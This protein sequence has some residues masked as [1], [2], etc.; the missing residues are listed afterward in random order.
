MGRTGQR[1]ILRFYLLHRECVRRN[2]RYRRAYRTVQAITDPERHAAE[3]V[4]LSQSWGLSPSEDPP[5]PDNWPQADPENL[6]RDVGATKDTIDSALEGCDPVEL[7]AAIQGIDILRTH[8]ST[9]SQ[10]L[11]GVLLLLH[12]PEQPSP[13]WGI[14]AIDLRRPKEEIL[15]AF[16][17]LLDQAWKGRR[18][19]RGPMRGPLKKGFDYLRVYDLREKEK[20]RL[21]EIGGIMWPEKIEEDTEQKAGVYV[22]KATAMIHHPP[23]LYALDTQLERRR[24]GRARYLE[25]TRN[26]PPS[27]SGKHVWLKPVQ[28]SNGKWV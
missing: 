27:A 21:K 13:P 20:K 5:D 24:Q 4:F 16:R 17:D 25:E 14:A 22:R 11:P 8:L 23:L 3:M 10:R 28:L 15:E 18:Q 7:D 6:L 12:V 26:C 2:S 9:L 1:D 19:G